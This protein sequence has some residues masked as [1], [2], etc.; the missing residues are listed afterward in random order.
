M[1]GS[2]VHWDTIR[3][4]QVEQ[5]GM[6]IN[7]QYYEDKHRERV[8]AKIKRDKIRKHVDPSNKSKQVG[9]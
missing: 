3:L 6:E 1:T 9:D 2:M 7:D 5:Y 8:N 4:K